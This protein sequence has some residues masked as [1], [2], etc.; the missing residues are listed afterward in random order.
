M[1]RT[2]ADTGPGE[3]LILQPCLS[4]LTSGARGQVTRSQDVFS[5][6][7]SPGPSG[8]RTSPLASGTSG[9][10]IRAWT[11]SMGSAGGTCRNST[12]DALRQVPLRCRWA[13]T[14]KPLPADRRRLLVMHLRVGGDLPQPAEA[15]G[16]QRV[17]LHH[18]IAVVLDQPA[19]FV[20]TDI[21]PTPGDRDITGRGEAARVVV[22]VAAERFLHPEDAERGELAAGEPE[23]G[24]RR[25]LLRG[26]HF[27]PRRTARAEAHPVP[28]R[29]YGRIML[30]HTQYLNRYWGFEVRGDSR[31][32]LHRPIDHEMIGYDNEITTRS[33]VLSPRTPCGHR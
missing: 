15:S 29:S 13:T 20:Q 21:V 22:G 24:R 9:S 5:S 2:D 18:V 25:G 23:R 33:L 11:I 31:R 3:R 1:I 4:C 26:N 28:G 16:A 14:P 10:V 7:P 17:R 19:A 6:T 8:K 12:Q 30:V 27:G 32:L